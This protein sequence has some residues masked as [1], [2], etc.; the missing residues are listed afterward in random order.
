M[1]NGIIYKLI[2]PD[3]DKCYIGSSRHSLNKRF[4]QHKSRYNN[5]LLGKGKKYTAFEILKNPNCTIELI[6]EFNFNNK[7]ELLMKEKQ[8]IKDNINNVINK[9]I[10]NRSLQEYYQD[11]KQK[12]K[13]YY[14]NNRDDK[15][16]YQ[17]EYYL[18]NI[19]KER[20]Q[21]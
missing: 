9:N 6:E 7:E 13:D 17:N 2:S 16:K 3:C 8:Y 21:F 4:S 10:P 18:K 19:K 14:F 5:F 11:N 15:L 12:Y 20:Y 1:F